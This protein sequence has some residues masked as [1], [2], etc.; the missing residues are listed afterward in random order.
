MKVAPEDAYTR[1]ICPRSTAYMQNGNLLRR[2]SFSVKGKRNG[3]ERTGIAWPDAGDDELLAARTAL[4]WVRAAR[5]PEPFHPQ[6]VRTF[7]FC[8][9]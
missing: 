5:L 4:L 8:C 7:S 1:K 6:G 2:S 9:L 3:D